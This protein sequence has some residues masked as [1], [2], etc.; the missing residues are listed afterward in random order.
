MEKN[1]IKVDCYKT[2][3]S[4]FSPLYLEIND[5]IKLDIVVKENISSKLIL[6]GNSDYSIDIKLEN[7]SNLLVNS[8]N[9]NNHVNVNVTLLENSTITY[10]HSVSAKSDS[11]NNFNIN[12][13]NNSSISILNNNGINMDNNKLFFNINGIVPK[14]LH[15]ITCN[16]SS[17]IINF[18][19]GNS[20]IIPNLIIDSNDIIANHSAY[21]GEIGEEE[22]FYMKSRGINEI[23]IK[24]LIYKGVLLGKM[25]LG[26]EKEEFNKIINEWW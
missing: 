18:K 8:L 6:I 2:S 3:I 16:Q 7:G 12:H 9:K 13:L 24:K 11:V 20:K 14:N 26:E 23:D 15:N 5:D 19:D 25:D 1:K 4:S 10:N 17:K 21:I 22:L